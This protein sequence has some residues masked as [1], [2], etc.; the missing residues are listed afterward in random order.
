MLNVTFSHG[1]GLDVHKRTV[2]ATRIGLR[3]EGSESEA[4]EQETAT[5]GTT[6]AEL[7]ALL[8]WLLV[9]E[10]SH[11]A[12]ESTGVYWQPI[13]NVLE[14]SLTVWLVNAQHLK[15][16]PGRK[17]DVG[18]SAPQ[19]HPLAQVMGLGLVKPSFIPPP[20]QRELRELTRYRIKWVA[21]R[22][23]RGQPHPEGARRGQHQAGECG[24]RGAGQVGAGD[25]G[26]V[27]GW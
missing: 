24:K 18:D 8:D 19:G 10:V 12:M 2:V 1:A 3:G 6:T 7:L 11:V 14:G 26:G 9:W 22:G 21:R 23:M 27:G 4:A 15:Q 16:V 17:T 20:A 5:F 25:A 13:D